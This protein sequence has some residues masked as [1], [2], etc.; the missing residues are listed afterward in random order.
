[1]TPCVSKVLYDVQ[2]IFSYIYSLSLTVIQQEA[3]AGFTALRLE[4][5]M[6]THKEGLTCPR[7]HSW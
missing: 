6:L 1:M 7:P 3:V 5:R 2:S 4:A